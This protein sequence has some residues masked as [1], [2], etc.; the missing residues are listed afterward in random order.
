MQRLRRDSLTGLYDIEAIVIRRRSKKAEAVV[1][2]DAG[3]PE[4]RIKS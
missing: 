3:A 1:P 2:N 4:N